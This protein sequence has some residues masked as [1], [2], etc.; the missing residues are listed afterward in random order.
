[1]LRKAF[2]TMTEQTVTTGKIIPVAICAS[3]KYN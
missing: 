1:M 2:S 3:S